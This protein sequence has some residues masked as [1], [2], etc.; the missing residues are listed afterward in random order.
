MR[1]ALIAAIAIAAISPAC[2]AGKSH[3]LA[4]TMDE[5][6]TL[7]F[8]GPIATVYIGN[9]TIADITMIDSKHAFVQGKTYGHTNIVALN[10]DGVQVYNT[11]IDVIEAA[12]STLTLNRG[13]QRVTYNC[14]GGRCEPTPVPG[15]AKD[16]FDQIAG[17]IGGHADA[18]RKAAA[19]N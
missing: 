9:P 10:H 16:V 19:T 3:G 11:R 2:A 8:K 18:A 7:T 12:A 15:D 14:G 6:R 1:C 13:A 17:Q 4:L 5:V